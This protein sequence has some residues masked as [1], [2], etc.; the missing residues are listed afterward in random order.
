VRAQLFER[1]TIPSTPAAGCHDTPKN[2]G[3][4][5]FAQMRQPRG[6]SPHTVAT[7]TQ[8][9]RGVREQCQGIPQHERIIIDTGA[10]TL[11]ET[12]KSTC[13]PPI[14]NYPFPVVKEEEEEEEVRMCE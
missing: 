4:D 8:P 12:L 6:C 1:D 2:G 7:E 13:S 3:R 10:E 5:Q 9:K 11:P 14:P